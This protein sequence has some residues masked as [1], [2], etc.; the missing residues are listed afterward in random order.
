MGLTPFGGLKT[1]GYGDYVPATSFGRI[2]AIVLMIFGIGI[3]AVLTSFLAA[4]VIRLQSDPE[5]IAA[6]VKQE[7]AIRAELVELKEIIKAGANKDD[8][9]E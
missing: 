6:I 7:A 1:V 9:E 5:D 8:A 3:F 4:G 2:L